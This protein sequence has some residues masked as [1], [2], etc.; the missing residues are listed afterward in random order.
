MAAMRLGQ[1]LARQAR[2][3]M[4]ADKQAHDTSHAIPRAL[5]EGSG[6]KAMQRDDERP[7]QAVSCYAVRDTC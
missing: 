6:S 7:M 2:R 5:D 3:T 4:G 1:L